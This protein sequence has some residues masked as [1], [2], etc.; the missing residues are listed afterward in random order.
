MLIVECTP[1][2]CPF[3][4]LATIKKRKEH[5]HPLRFLINVY[6]LS[7]LEIVGVHSHYTTSFYSTQ[8]NKWT[9]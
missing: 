2:R 5:R 3:F 8:D 6:M 4:S 7:I 9:Q 1:L